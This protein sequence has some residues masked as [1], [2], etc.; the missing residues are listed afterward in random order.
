NGPVSFSLIS[1][2]RSPRNLQVLSFPRRTRRRICDTIIREKRFEST[3]WLASRVL[4][5]SI[6]GLSL[7]FLLIVFVVFERRHRFGPAFF[8][9]S[10]IGRHF[11]GHFCHFSFL[12]SHRATA[13]PNV[14]DPDVARLRRIRAHLFAS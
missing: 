11:A 4:Y 8:P 3:S 9:D 6:N 10:R 12:R 5:L 2:C 13:R 1:V 14:V 7:H